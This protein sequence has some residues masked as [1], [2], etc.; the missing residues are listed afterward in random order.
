MTNLNVNLGSVT[1]SPQ[2]ESIQNKSVGF[3]NRT[4]QLAPTPDIS[5]QRLTADSGHRSIN[6]RV[7]VLVQSPDIGKQITANVMSKSAK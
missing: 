5:L 7:L 1:H 6:D 3:K 2:T 4:V